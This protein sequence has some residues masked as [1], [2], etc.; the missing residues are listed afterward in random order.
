MSVAA[1]SKKKKATRDTGKISELSPSRIPWNRTDVA[2][3]PETPS[4]LQEYM[5]CAA[6][7]IYFFVNYC[8]ILDPVKGRIPF[9]L[10]A[11]QRA[12]V[13]HF[14]RYRFNIVLKP[15]Q[16]GLSWLVSCYALW[17]A[18]FRPNQNIVVISIKEEVAKRFMDKIQYTWKNLPPWLKGTVDN[19]NTSTMEWHNNSRIMSI[20]TSEEAG[21]SEGLSL[22][23]V[24][25]AAFVRHIN[26]IWAAAF[27][28][29]STGGMAILISTANGLGNLFANKWKDA[30]AGESEFNPIQ[31]HWLMHPERDQAWYDTQRR[32]LGPALCAQEVD[33][34]FL[35]SG[36]PVFDTTILVEWSE[37]LRRRKPM[38]T[39]YAPENKYLQADHRALYDKR[40]E[41]LYIFQE[42][43]KGRFYIIGA[44]CSSGD[45]GDYGAVQV[46]DWETGIQVAEMRIQAKPDIFT[47]YLVGIGK[48][49]GYAQIAPDRNG[50]GL[51]VVQKLIDYHYPNLYVYVQ[52]EA[53][54]DPEQST[55]KIT[56]EKKELVGFTTTSAN[57]SVIIAHG[58][59]M[60]R[61]Y[62]GLRVSGAA[63]GELLLINGMRTLNE[64]L[65]FNHQET[66][67]PNPR[68]NDGY[69]DDLVMAY[70]IGQHARLRYKPTL[71]LPVIFQ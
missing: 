29:L 44:D 26:K 60:I 22:L 1:P 11:F 13:K 16:M 31:L 57:R 49:Y 7:P 12:T 48:M 61:D 8:L 27:P 19:K 21:R 56:T 3:L 9:L 20:P 70:F 71:Q 23:I 47:Q 28:T 4:E 66:G 52:E 6:N 45:G 53:K 36:R 51:A 24:D 69:N 54:V 34:D 59:Q 58:E 14:L 50:N 68:A 32:E 55:K 35:N 41:G 43:I 5:K 38:K 39:L 42:Y 33:C 10:Y 2:R 64:M 63:R 17:L 40:A 18:L 30:L 67:K 25:E 62:E 15:R 46:F 37:V 65:V